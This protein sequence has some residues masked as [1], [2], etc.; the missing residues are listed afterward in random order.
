MRPSPR[1]RPRRGYAT[2]GES[3]RPVVALGLAVGGG[4]LW[5]ADR[6]ANAATRIDLA[7]GSVKGVIGVGLDP[8]VLTFGYGTLWVANSDDTTISAIRPGVRRVDTI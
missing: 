5:V 1:G 8:L 4:S 3:P 6:L 7:D 2:G